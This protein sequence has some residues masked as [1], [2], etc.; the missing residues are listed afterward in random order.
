MYSVVYR[1]K[2]SKPDGVTAN[3]GSYKTEALAVKAAQQW[4]MAQGGMYD[5]WI[6]RPYMKVVPK[7]IPT[8]IEAVAFDVNGQIIDK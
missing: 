6:A 7:E 1:A 2:N 5:V 8:I 4:L 3:A